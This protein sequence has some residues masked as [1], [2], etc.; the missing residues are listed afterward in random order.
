MI[1]QGK[2][3]LGFIDSD[4][5]K[6]SSQRFK[7]LG[8]FII[9]LWILLASGCDDK[10]PP[11]LKVALGQAFP[12]LK[13]ENLINQPISIKPVQGKVLMINV[14]ATWCAPCRHEL[15]SLQ[16]L[17]ESLGEDQFTLLALS[18]DDDEHLVSEYL[19]DKKI[20]I[21]SYIDKDLSEVEGILG[22]RVFPST[23]VIDQN[24]IL[25]EITE[26]WLEWDT[27]EIVASMRQ[28][29]PGSRE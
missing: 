16:R 2:I 8:V 28:L 12:E 19:I 20:D 27:S 11:P 5:V 14:W 17:A 7:L 9:G 4:R 3:Y 29:L 10:K 15:P 25:V 13:V 18:I 24:G 6:F 23:F 26:G 21:T 22:V 1:F